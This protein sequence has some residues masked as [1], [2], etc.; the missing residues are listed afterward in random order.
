MGVNG[1]ANDMDDGQVDE[2]VAL[3]MVQGQYVQLHYLPVRFIPVRYVPI[4]YIPAFNVPVR[5]IPEVR[6]LYSGLG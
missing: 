5:F 4:C 2:L 3:W 6:G 1:Q